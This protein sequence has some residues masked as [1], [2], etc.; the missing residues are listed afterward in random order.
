MGGQTGSM[1]FLRKLLP[2]PKRYPDGIFIELVDIIFAGALPVIVIGVA[3]VCICALV[4]LKTGD[5]FIIIL[6]IANFFLSIARAVSIVIYRRQKKPLAFKTAQLW[7]RRYAIGAYTQAILIGTFSARVLARG[8]PLDAMLITGLI[9]GY[10]SG[11]VTRLAVRPVICLVSL[12][13]AVIPTVISFA[14][15]I[16]GDAGLYAMVA[17]AQQALLISGFAFVSLETVAHTYR[18]TLQQLTS[19]HD[20]SILAGQDA[21]TGLPNRTL[22]QA[23]FEDGVARS[24]LSGELMAL[25]YLDLD[26]FKSVNDNLGHPTGDAVLQAVAGRITGMLRMGDTAARMGG[27][28]FVILQVE[29]HS[30]DEARLLAHRILRVVNAPYQINGNEIYIGA[31]IGVALRWRDGVDLKILTARADA[32]LYQAK[33]EGRGSI[34]VWNETP[35]VPEIA[36]E[37]TAA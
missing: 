34:V 17:Y 24:G 12:A 8:D 9:F 31:S 33:R 25:L 35:L 18:T 23:R 29:I 21:L 37:T 3:V 1:R 5:V 4:A 7:E 28:E 19:K 22:L 10:G 11:V 36:A 14:M 27:D 30:A 26:Q 15:H 16:G 2:S 6:T 32:A 13:L 20:L